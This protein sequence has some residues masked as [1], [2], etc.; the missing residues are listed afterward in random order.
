MWIKLMLILM[1][2]FSCQSQTGTVQYGID[3]TS[4]YLPKLVGKR[5]GLVVNH[6][7]V[8]RE[9]T[10]LIEI[11]RQN[12]IHIQVMF[13]PEH[14]IAGDK[15]DG[16]R[17]DDDLANRIV[18]LYGRTKKPTP[19]HLDSVDVLIYDIQDV[20]VRCYTF[21]STLGYVM[22]A[23][24]ETSIPILVFDRPNPLGRLIE[25]PIRTDSLSSFVGLY[26]IPI[27]YGLTVGELAILIQRRGW[28]K[29]MDRLK[30][31]VIEMTGWKPSAQALD[32]PRFRPTSPNIP[33]VETLHLYPGLVLFEGTNLS[34]GRGTDQAFSQIGAPWLKVDSLMPILRA[35][36]PLMDFNETT[37]T[38]K[39]IPGKAWNP[40]FQDQLCNGI[41]ISIPNP[42]GFQSVAFGIRLMNLIHQLHPEFKIDRQ[43][44]FNLILGQVGKLPLK[45]NETLFNPTSVY[46]Y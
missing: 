15:A 25:G 22:E 26:P 31:T 8:N 46:R 20:G 34:V 28:M 14:S 11:L 32:D 35:E 30:L 12:Q 1:A 33:T 27:R 24:A 43:R 21:I 44:H 23:A 6:T 16:E 13:A 41:E 38:P 7:S 19:E 37:F 9:G 39:N 2:L 17:L 42:E 29:A 3:R 36:F 45:V 4:V 10:H 40:K 18:S 5:V